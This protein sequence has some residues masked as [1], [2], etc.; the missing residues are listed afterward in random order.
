[1]AVHRIVKNPD[2]VARAGNRYGKKA[3]R[4]PCTG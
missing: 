2:Q 3:R 1:L 4:S